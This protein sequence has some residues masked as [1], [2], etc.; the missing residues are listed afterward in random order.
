MAS[1]VPDTWQAGVPFLITFISELLVL[2]AGG[3]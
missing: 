3:S 2:S 1:M